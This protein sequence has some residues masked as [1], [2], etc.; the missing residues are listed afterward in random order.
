LKLFEAEPS[1]AERPDVDA[2]TVDQLK[3]AVL[4]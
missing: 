2:M 1:M 4:T 3:E